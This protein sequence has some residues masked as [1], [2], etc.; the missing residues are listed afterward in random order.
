MARENNNSKVHPVEVVLLNDP[1]FAGRVAKLR[2]ATKQGKKFG[3]PR[4]RRS[5]N[6]RRKGRHINR[7]LKK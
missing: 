1:D 4:E 2:R 3:R 7:W 5:E 6:R